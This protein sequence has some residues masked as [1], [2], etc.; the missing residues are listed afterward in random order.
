MAYMF[1]KLGIHTSLP[2]VKKISEIKIIFIKWYKFM[3][4]ILNF[5]LTCVKVYYNIKSQQ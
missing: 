2:P 1:L 4:K 3:K 5:M